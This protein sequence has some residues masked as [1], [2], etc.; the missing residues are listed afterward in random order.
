MVAICQH[1]VSS[2]QEKIMRENVKAINFHSVLLS[3]VPPLILF[4]LLPF[5]V[6]S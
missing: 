6:L 3:S 5:L 4:L 1:V 2:S